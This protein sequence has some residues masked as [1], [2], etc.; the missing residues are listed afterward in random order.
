MVEQVEVAW[1]AHRARRDLQTTVGPSRLVGLL[2][3][4]LAAVIV[5][6][7]LSS[8]ISSN[9]DAIASFY[10]IDAILASDLADARGYNAYGWG[11]YLIWRDVPV[12]I[13]G[14]ADVYGDDFMYLYFQAEDAERD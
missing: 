10:P 3:G 1:D 12:F 2:A 5:T 4:G 6:L 13:D 8:A 7:F 9:D 14:R 11:G